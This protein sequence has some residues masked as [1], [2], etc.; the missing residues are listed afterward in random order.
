[1]IATGPGLFSVLGVGLLL[2]FRHAFEPDHL[3]AVTTLASRQAKVRDAL[4]LG[5]SWAA[6]HTAT[7]ALAALVTITAGF[8]L[9]E[10]LWPIAEAVVAIFLM[11]LGLIVI[12]S[13]ARGRW[14]L[15]SH[16]HDGEAHMHLHSH[17]RGKSHQHRHP[18]TGA[19]WALGFGLMHGLAGSGAVLALLVAATPVTA[20][21]WTCL[22]AFG[23]GTVAGMLLVSA[24]LWSAVRMASHDLRWVTALRLASGIASVAVGA[25]MVYETVLGR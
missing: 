12:A 19:R 5:I 20:A 1:L 25:T 6:G 11:G 10:R 4:G 23:L 17:A 3:A 9:P 15:H 18:R 16:T 24:A 8:R 7:I 14:H 13:W 21:R 2:G 22:G